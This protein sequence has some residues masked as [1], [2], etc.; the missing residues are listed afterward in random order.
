MAKVKTKKTTKKITR[1][2]VEKKLKDPNL[3]NAQKD[4]LVKDYMSTL[5]YKKSK[6]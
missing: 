5:D 3:S 1:A 6:R 2:E 4:K